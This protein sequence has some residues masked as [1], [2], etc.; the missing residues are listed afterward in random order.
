VAEADIVSTTKTAT[1]AKNVR[2]MERPHSSATTANLNLVAL[3]AAT[4]NA[5]TG[6]TSE[7]AATVAQAHG[8]LEHGPYASTASVT[9]RRQ[10][11]E[12]HSAD[13]VA[14]RRQGRH[15]HHSSAQS[16]ARHQGNRTRT[17]Y[18]AT[19]GGPVGGAPQTARH[20]GNRTTPGRIITPRQ[21]GQSDQRRQAQKRNHSPTDTKEIA[22]P[23]DAL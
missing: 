20:Q 10:R 16:P 18:N 23:Q 4:R 5:S 21:G 17:H 8:L 11:A 7:D 13:S 22:P 1:S 9:T 14:R 3:S 15:E 12:N 6:I 2:T 19:P